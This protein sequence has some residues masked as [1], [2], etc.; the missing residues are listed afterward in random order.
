MHDIGFDHL[1]PSPE[2]QAQLSDAIWNADNVEMTTVGVDVGSS[3]SHL[4][5]ARVHLQRLSEA[6]SSRFVVVNRE[7]LWRSPILLTPYRSD[8]T[9]DSNALKDFFDGAFYEAKL[10]R[11]EIDSGAVILTGEALKRKNAR[12]I[13]DLF[14]EESGKFVCASAGHNLEALMAAH[15]SGAVALSKAEHKTI[16][17]VDIGGGTTKLALLHGGRILASAAIAVGG[18]LIAFGEGGELVRIEGPARQIAEAAGVTLEEGGLLSADDQGRMIKAMVDV[19]IETIVQAPAGDLGR[20]L[21]LTPPLPDTPKPDGITFSGGVAEYIFKREIA[22]HEDLG[23]P[24]AESLVKVLNDKRIALPVYDPGQGIR[25]TVVGASQF[26][27]QVSGNTIHVT[28][29]HDLP[30]HNVPVLKLNLDLSGDFTSDQVSAEIASA[31][32][33][34]DMREG[35]TDVALALAWQGQPLH[36]RLYALASGVCQGLSRSLAAHRP[37]ILVMDGDIGK[38]MGEILRRELKVEGP[39]ISVDGIRLEDFDYVD[40]GEM[41]QPTNVVPLIIKSLLFATPD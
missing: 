21:A 6:L 17:N 4:M 12:A 23:R 32:G 28:G 19:L 38:T 30:I 1:H 24:L 40:I 5:F 29:D 39:I 34:F 31:M 37:L 27:V 7:I 11:D 20:A 25:A 8:Y 41:I 15:G 18:R 33:R 9:I 26:S 3:T 10:T 13:A 14:A 16:L 36:A 2:Q 35:E 22:E